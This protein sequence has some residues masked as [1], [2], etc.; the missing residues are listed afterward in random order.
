ML[1]LPVYSKL[2]FLIPVKS[3]KVGEFISRKHFIQVKSYYYYLLN[4]FFFVFFVL[5][6]D[7]GANINIPPEIYY[8]FTTLQKIDFLTKLFQVV[9][10]KFHI[11]SYCCIDSSGCVFFCK[12]IMGF[13]RGSIFLYVFDK[14]IEI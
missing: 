2:F 6:F 12:K 9:R 1:N 11:L 4:L 8:G 14:K 10:M 13:T 5:Q 3:L 7:K